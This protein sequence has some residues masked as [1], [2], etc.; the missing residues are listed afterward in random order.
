MFEILP[1]RAYMTPLR[2][3]HIQDFFTLKYYILVCNIFSY[4]YQSLWQ[5][6]Y[7]TGQVLAMHK[8]LL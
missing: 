7:K 3:L 5:S 6:G 4:T 1:Q 8:C 2:L